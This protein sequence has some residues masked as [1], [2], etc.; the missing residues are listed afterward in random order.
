M[1]V[2]EYETRKR[3]RA[4]IL[5]DGQCSFC[6]RQVERI[7]RRD[8][9]GKFDYLAFED[10]EVKRR[11]G[12]LDLDDVEAGMRLIT[13]EERVY[14]GSDAVYQIARR[15]PSWRVLSWLYRVPGARRFFTCI[16]GWIARN[17]HRLGPTCETDRCRR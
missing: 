12:H 7:R 4:C 10:A 8:R 6:G 3:G 1:R 15:I 17:R 14:A 9:H 16:Y 2:Q 5:Y 13:P 11:F